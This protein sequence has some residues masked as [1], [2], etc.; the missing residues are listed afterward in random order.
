MAR[1]IDQRGI[2]LSADHFSDA[3]YVDYVAVGEYDPADI[4]R[5][6]ERIEETASSAL[7]LHIDEV[8][9]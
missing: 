5:T 2:E 9:N 6:L 4:S 8:S 3:D 1:A 7:G